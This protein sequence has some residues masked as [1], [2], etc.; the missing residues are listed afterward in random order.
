MFIRETLNLDLLR[1]R[2]EIHCMVL[3]KDCMVL[4]KGCLLSTEIVRCMWL[5]GVRGGVGSFFCYWKWGINGTLCVCV[6]LCVWMLIILQVSMCTCV[7]VCMC[8]HEMCVCVCVLES[9]RERETFVK[10]IIMMR[11]D[12]FHDFRW[13][14]QNGS[15]KLTETCCLSTIWK[16]KVRFSLFRFL[17]P[18]LW[19]V[20]GTT[21]D[22]EQHYMFVHK[23]FLFILCTSWRIVS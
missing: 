1:K 11:N 14:I 8:V 3:W 15:L 12:L 4:R 20:S 10:Y 21:T 18:C 13:P 6:C 17:L 16:A 9:E 19:I 2:R 5:L 7:L 23:W 22:F